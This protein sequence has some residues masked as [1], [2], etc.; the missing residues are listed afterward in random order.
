MA[1]MT[2][3]AIKRR[4]WASG[5]GDHES[6]SGSQVVGNVTKQYLRLIHVLE[7]LRTHRERGHAAL[8]VVELLLLQKVT[9]REVG[10]H[11]AGVRG[12]H[13]TLYPFGA[14]VDPS[15]VGLRKG[16]RQHQGEFALATSNLKN[17]R[18]RNRQALKR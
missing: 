7:H 5:H 11:A 13:G 1:T 16:L 17:Y 18:H 10:R 3:V 4:P 8:V 12:P 15:H 9:L 6:T 14:D 2:D